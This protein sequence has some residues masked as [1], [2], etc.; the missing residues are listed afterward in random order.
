MVML[1]QAETE[2]EKAIT[3]LQVKIRGILLTAFE[4]LPTNCLKPGKAATRCVCAVCA[5]GLPG[6]AE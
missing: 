1:Q 4:L 2:H 5:E 3:G 6:T